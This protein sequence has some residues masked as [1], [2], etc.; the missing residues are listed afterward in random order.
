[1]PPLILAALFALLALDRSLNRSDGGERNR[2]WS[3]YGELFM[4]C[5]DSC[6]STLYHRFLRPFPGRF[7]IHRLLNEQLSA[8]FHFLLNKALATY[9]ASN[10][11]A[12]DFP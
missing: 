1:M 7:W 5:L 3:Y 11:F 8:F 10:D 4:C 9:F 6:L 2:C 12:A